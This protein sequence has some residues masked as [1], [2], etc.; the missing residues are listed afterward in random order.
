MHRAAKG[1]AAGAVRPAAV[2]SLRRPTALHKQPSKAAPAASAVP[3]ASGQ[4]SKPGNTP[5]SA[6]Q[7]IHQRVSDAAARARGHALP[8]KQAAAGPAMAPSRA[9][10]GTA[11]PAGGSGRAE[12]RNAPGAAAA[13]S[14]PRVPMFNGKAEASGPASTRPGRGPAAP[15]RGGPAKAP[16][17]AAKVNSG[18]REAEQGGAA[19][20][21][22][23]QHLGRS[24]PGPLPASRVHASPEKQ[25]LFLLSCQGVRP[26]HCPET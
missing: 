6:L 9:A 4:P 3:G 24:G 5:Q 23:D 12:A 17:L 10:R 25:V 26:R 16:H 14:V 8:P 11:R 18:S 1:T 21:A 13:R 7:R 19:S 2:S 15:R 20:R 22:P